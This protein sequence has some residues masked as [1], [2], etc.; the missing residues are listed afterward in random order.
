M[1][2]T[3]RN[4]WTAGGPHMGVD[5]VPNCFTGTVCNLVNKVVKDIIYLPLV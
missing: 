2:G 4:L 5:L 3:V 1:P